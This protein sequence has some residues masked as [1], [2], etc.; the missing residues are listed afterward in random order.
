MKEKTEQNAAEIELLKNY[1]PQRMQQIQNGLM[2]VL[3]FLTRNFEG[4]RR[5]FMMFTYSNGELCDLKEGG[6]GGLLAAWMMLVFDREEAMMKVIN[7][8]KYAGSRAMHHMITAR[9]VLKAM[10]RRIT[11]RPNLKAVPRRSKSQPRWRTIPPMS[12]TQPEWRRIPCR[13]TAQANLTTTP[14]RSTTRSTL[15]PTRPLPSNTE[16]AGG[17]LMPTSEFGGLA[18]A[19]C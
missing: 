17:R 3:D 5:I 12:T 16:L 6:F 13:N 1:I 15:H 8:L 18:S 4:Q 9:P 14:H 2:A 7:E 11:R 10:P 19:N